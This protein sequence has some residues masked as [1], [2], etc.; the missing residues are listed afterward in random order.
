MYTYS[1]KLT[2]LTAVHHSRST[3]CM[4]QT[5]FLYSYPWELMVQ[6]AFRKY[7][8]P[9]NPNVKSLD[10]LERRVTPSG[11]LHSRRLFGTLWN[12]PSIV[13]KVNVCCMSKYLMVEPYVC[14][15]LEFMTKCS[16]LGLQN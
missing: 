4:R 2:A 5:C 11:E 8:N 10:T 1:G 6:A 9:F 13:M 12:V 15:A 7:P 14:I 3:C 16:L